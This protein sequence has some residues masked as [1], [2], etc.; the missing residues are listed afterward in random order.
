MISF[1]DLKKKEQ[2]RKDGSNNF[3]ENPNKGKIMEK[4]ESYFIRKVIIVLQIRSIYLFSFL[5]SRIDMLA[6][7][8]VELPPYIS[9]FVF[10]FINFSL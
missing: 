2:L 6:I 4:A 3:L 1:I 8:D 9:L 10:L 7:E 5:F